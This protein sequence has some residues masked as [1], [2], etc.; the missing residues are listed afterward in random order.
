MHL[1][2][3]VTHHHLAEHTADAIRDV[4][5]DPQQQHVAN[6]SND[7]N[8]IAIYSL[9]LYSPPPNVLQYFHLD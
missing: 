1:K 5:T 6:L 8:E 2:V 7:D 4:T 9:H 3:S